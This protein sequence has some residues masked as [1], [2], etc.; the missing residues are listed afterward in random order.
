[1][2]SEPHSI[3]SAK[4]ISKVGTP[5]LYSTLLETIQRI[6]TIAHAI[7]ICTK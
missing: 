4:K 6:T 1:M 2:A 5:S 7:I 3:P